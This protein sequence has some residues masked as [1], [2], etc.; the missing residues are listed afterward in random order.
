MYE[1]SKK[2]PFASVPRMV[3]VEVPAVVGVPA[4]TPAAVSVMPAGS[5]SFHLSVR[6]EGVGLPKDLNPRTA[7]SLGMRIVNAFIEQ[8]NGSMEVVRRN[9]GTEIVVTIPKQAAS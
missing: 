5:D 8:L 3:K 4:S 1:S 6:D 9:P 2:H 7:K